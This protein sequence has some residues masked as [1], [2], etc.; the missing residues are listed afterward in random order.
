M[1]IT[2]DSAKAFAILAGVAVAGFVAWKLYQGADKVADVFVK[3][4]NPLS[5][6]N[7]IYRQFETRDEQGN[8]TGTL[9]TDVYD[10]FHHSDGSFKWPWE[11]NKPF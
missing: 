11:E 3:D 1:K 8:V 5:T 2:A 9:G 10:A 6:E 7:A 4:L